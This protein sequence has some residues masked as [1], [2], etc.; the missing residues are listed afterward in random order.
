MTNKSSEEMKLY[1]RK[2]RENKRK[3]IK[4]KFG[5]KCTVCGSTESLEFDHIERSTK[6]EAIASLLTHKK[7]TLENELNKCQ[8]LCK[9]C[10]YIKSIECGDLP[11]AVHGSHQMYKRGCRCNICVIFVKNYRK[12][13]YIK[14]GK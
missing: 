7:E 6:V 11:V 5:G 4:E 2:Y 3:Y 13:Y 14:T 1:M 9:E 10:H 8:L 12:E